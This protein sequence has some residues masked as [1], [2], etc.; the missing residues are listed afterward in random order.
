MKKIGF[1]I[2]WYGDEIPG[3]AEADLR[4]LAKHMVKRGVELEILT[5]C[6]KE[7]LGNWGKNYHKPGIYEEGGLTVRRFS[8]KERNER[9][10]GEVNYKL[11]KGQYQLTKR[12]ER[13]FVDEM[14]NSPE[15]Y[16]YIRKHKN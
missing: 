2:P 12:D 10:F 5:T 8:V 9:A 7:F 1:V 15:L 13:I 4:G 14:I 16:E 11:M 6:V 3:G